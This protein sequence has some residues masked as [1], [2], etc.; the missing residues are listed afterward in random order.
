MGPHDALSPADAH[1]RIP[2]PA[3]H[4]SSGTGRKRRRHGRG[5]CHRADAAATRVAAGRAFQL[6]EL[7]LPRPRSPHSEAHWPVVR[8]VHPR[9]HLHAAWHERLRARQSRSDLASRRV[10]HRDAQRSRQR[11]PSFRSNRSEHGGG[12]VL[13]GGRSH[14]VAERFVRRQGDLE[15]LAAEDDDAVQ[16][17]HT[18]VARRRLPT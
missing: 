14:A 13:D 9:E 3:A 1:R 2:G 15:C 18:A 17:R 5:I 8:D 16:G 4:R 12:L 11:L 6:H 7:G 10:L